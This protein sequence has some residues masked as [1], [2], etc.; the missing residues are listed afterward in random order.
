MNNKGICDFLASGRNCFPRVN[1]FHL[2][3]LFFKP[4]S[5]FPRLLE[6]IK[7]IFWLLANLCSTFIQK[8]INVLSQNHSIHHYSKQSVQLFYIPICS[9]LCKIQYITTAATFPTVHTHH[10][11]GKQSYIAAACRGVFYD[12]DQ[13]SSLNLYV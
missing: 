4:T 13:N 10:A 5:F 1:F 3:S 2:S 7:K 6:F 8:G 9:V 12:W 11:L